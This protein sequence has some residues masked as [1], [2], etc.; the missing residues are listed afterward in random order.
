M[1]GHGSMKIIIL[2]GGIGSGKSTVGAI[3]KELGTV[4]IDSDLLARQVLEPCAPAFLETVEIFGRDILTA[5]GGIDR[6]KLGRIVFNNPEAL[7]KLNQIIH[8]RVDSVV[9]NL[10]QQYKKQGVKA[11]FI[12]MAVLAEAEAPFMSRVSAVW[13]VKSSKDIILERLKE[14]GVSEVEALSRM[15]N[16]PPKEGWVKSNLIVIL[17]NGDKSVLKDKIGKLWKDL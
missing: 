8:P 11:V 17:N 4:V 16:Q 15:A 3:L 5:Q 12:E 14:R 7:L 1:G 2:T 9:D 13:V 6:A 10:L